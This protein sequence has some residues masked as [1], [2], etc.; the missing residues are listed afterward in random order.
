MKLCKRTF[1]MTA[2]LVPWSLN[3]NSNELY[4]CMSYT[5]NGL[6]QTVTLQEIYFTVSIAHK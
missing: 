5:F 2:V 4:V 6:G 3:L 1:Y